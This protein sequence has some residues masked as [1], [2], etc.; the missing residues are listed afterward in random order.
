MPLWGVD[1]H[2]R[3]GEARASAR[4]GVHAPEHV[5]GTQLGERGGQ[6]LHDGCLA[7]A[8]GPDQHDAVAHQVRLVQLDALVEP[9]RVR[10]QAPLRHDLPR[11]RCQ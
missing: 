10:L 8:G 5:L 2:M 9:G 7:R 11:P 1:G 3:Q 6:A 4:L